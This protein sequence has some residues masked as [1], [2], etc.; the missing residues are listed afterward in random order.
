MDFPITPRPHVPR[1]RGGV[2]EVHS[3]SVPSVWC[4][5]CV[6]LCVPN[7]T[8]EFC[9]PWASRVVAHLSPTSLTSAMTGEYRTWR[10]QDDCTAH[11]FMTHRG[12]NEQRTL[13]SEVFHTLEHIGNA[14]MAISNAS[15]G[16]VELSASLLGATPPPHRQKPKAHARD[17]P[18]IKCRPQSLPVSTRERLEAGGSGWRASRGLQC[19]KA[20]SQKCVGSTSALTVRPQCERTRLLAAKTASWMECG[21]GEERAA[22]SDMWKDRAHRGGTAAVCGNAAIAKI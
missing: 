22:L 2:W 10:A 13:E 15:T 3:A 20:T 19:S 6:L 1:Q 9:G 16:I 7:P 5:S 4:V 12:C 14:A 17:P 8:R 18:P 11:P 21:S